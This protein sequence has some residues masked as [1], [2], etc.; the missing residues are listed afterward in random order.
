MRQHDGRVQHYLQQALRGAH[1]LQ[2]HVPHGR[3]RRRRERL[4]GLRRSVLPAVRRVRRRRLRDLPRLVPR[5]HRERPGPLPGGAPG[6]RAPAAGL[7]HAAQDR[8]GLGRL[9]HVDGVGAT[10]RVAVDVRE[11]DQASPRAHPQQRVGGLRRGV[12]DAAV[13]ADGSVRAAVPDPVGRTGHGCAEEPFVPQVAGGQG[14][15]AL[16]W[17]A[18]KRLAIEKQ[19]ASGRDLVDRRQR[20]FR[21][22]RF[23]LG[24]RGW[25]EAI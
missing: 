11:E 7:R 15:M 25:P 16:G 5:L 18:E 1:V 19:A 13:L 14:L 8:D 22:G 23:A 24:H 9:L 3:V 10:L 21:A 2:P 4:P 12:R 20:G 17:P 6:A